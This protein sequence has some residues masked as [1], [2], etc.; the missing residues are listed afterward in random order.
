[1]TAQDKDPGSATLEELAAYWRMPDVLAGPLEREMARE[2]QVEGRE[3]Q[4]A[5]GKIAAELEHRVL[6]P[7][8]AR[9]VEVEPGEPHVGIV[10]DPAA[11]LV[12]QARL[13]LAAYA[14]PADY[15][16][17]VRFLGLGKGL[18]EKGYWFLAVGE[19]ALRLERFL[20]VGMEWHVIGSRAV[21]RIVRRDTWQ[22]SRNPS[23]SRCSAY[24][25]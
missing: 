2:S 10:P 17:I 1:M 16:M 20:T 3:A 23:H 9:H 21:L 12:V 18:L 8:V 5:S 6:Q 11:D 19:Y 13:S 14:V 15:P 22:K 4:T 24:G 25:S 7:A